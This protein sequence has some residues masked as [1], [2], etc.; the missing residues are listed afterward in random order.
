LE[1]KTWLYLAAR[2]YGRFAMVLGKGLNGLAWTMAA[3][4]FAV[5]LAYFAVSLGAHEVDRYHGADIIVMTGLEA[6]LKSIAAMLGLTALAALAY[7]ALFAAIG[8][9]VPRR[10]M[11]IAFS[12]T[13][14]FEVLVS[15][16]PA[17]INRITVQYHLRCLLTSWIDL[18]FDRLPEG[19]HYLFSEW[20]AG[21]HVLCLLAMPLLWTSIALGVVHYRQYVTNDEA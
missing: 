12:Y 17:V 15:F 1:G 20:W 4:L 6:P 21:W 14:I 9:I 18:G 13:L 11:L 19:W 5:C 3:G 16:I 7:S 10:A 2:P 8:C